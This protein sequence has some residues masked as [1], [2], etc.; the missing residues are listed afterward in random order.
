MTGTPCRERVTMYAIAKFVSPSWR[1]PV[2]RRGCEGER[3]A[4]NESESAPLIF[5]CDA[6]ALR[7][8][9]GNFKHARESRLRA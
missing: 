6:L 7:I 8:D 4:S 2:T 1:N 3:I 9:A 5:L